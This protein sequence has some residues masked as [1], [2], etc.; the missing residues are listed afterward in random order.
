[1]FFPKCHFL[2]LCIFLGFLSSI[3][4]SCFCPSI[5]QGLWHL[6]MKPTLIR[7]MYPV[8]V[9]SELL[10]YICYME[11]LSSVLPH[12]I[13]NSYVIILS[14][15]LNERLLEDSIYTDCFLC[16]FFGNSTISI[17]PEYIGHIMTLELPF[18]YLSH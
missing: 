18:T 9:F 5:S 16:I 7:E 11:Y 10:I 3:H 2:L 14:L 1:M 13:I 15:S 6:S 8:S 4:T 12:C 17:Y